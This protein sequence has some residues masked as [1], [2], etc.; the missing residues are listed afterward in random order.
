MSVE[1]EVPKAPTSPADL[2]R[3]AFWVPFR[4]MLKVD[5]PEQIRSL[6]GLW[7]LQ[8][9]SA[10]SGRNLMLDEYRRCFGNSFPDADYK[11]IIK[12][13]YRAAF[14]V[15][16]EELLL[17]KL[18]IDNVENYIQFRGREHLDEALERKK[19]VLWLYPHAGAVM[20]MLAWLSLQGYPY[21]QY[22][23]RG[24]P[25]EDVAR[26]HPELLAANRWR[27]AVRQVREEN[28]DRLPAKFITLNTSVRELFRRLNKN[29]LVGIAYDGRI[30]N[31]WVPMDYLNR[32]A[33]LNPGPYRMAIQTGAAIVPA[34][35]HTPK[36]GPA[37]CHVGKPIY[38]EG[39]KWPALA[40]QL[41]DQQQRWLRRWPEEYGVW[42]VHCRERN[43]ID[44]HPLFVD[45]AHGDR[46]KKW[47][48]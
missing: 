13:A 42:L 48:R 34:F 26:D 46:Y 36:T 43:H 47:I 2:A 5:R 24:L 12:E 18:T 21:T 17:G 27:E 3:W 25:P 19:G 38:P 16:L 40:E 1:N 45:H 32:T 11:R 9:L 35:C 4:D 37:Q 23:A 7:R 30:G 28:E 33:L 44:D 6:H 41:L 8:W 29:E 15:H 10:R 20:Q 22:A 14:R 31:K 39:K